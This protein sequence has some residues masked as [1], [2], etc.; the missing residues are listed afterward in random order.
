MD[1]RVLSSLG[2]AAVRILGEVRDNA[3]LAPAASGP[4]LLRL[5]VTEGLLQHEARRRWPLERLVSG[6]GPRLRAVPR[7]APGAPAP[8]ASPTG[9]P[10]V[11]ASDVS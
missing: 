6:P 3:G 2:R 1:A 7:K 5:P 9:S 8:P 10:F 11:T 4:T